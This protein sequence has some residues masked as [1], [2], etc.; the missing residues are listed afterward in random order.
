MRL[1][2]FDLNL[3]VAFKAL[4][5]ER[6]VTR[7]AER[8]NIT[9]PAMSAALRRLRTAFNDELLVASGKRML[10][11]PHAQTLAP[12][13]DDIIAASRGLIASASLFDPATSQRQFRI[14][15]SDYVCAILIRPLLAR[16]HDV[17][18][19][20]AIQ[21]VPVGADSID[22]LEQGAIDCLIAPEPFVSRAHPSELLFEEGHVVVGWDRNPLFEVPMTLRDFE[23]ASHVVVEFSD[24]PSFAEDQVRSLGH[25]RRS[26]VSVPSFTMVPW[27]LPETQ[28][29]ALMHD[30]LA[31]L[32][33]QFFPLAIA[34]P[35][36]A[37]EPMRE[38]LQYNSLRETDAG[39][40]WLR[41]QLRHEVE[42]SA[43]G[44]D[45]P[46]RNARKAAS[47]R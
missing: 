16:I 5:D 10:P 31:R 26:E 9:Q 40:Q 15:T 8:L 18:P 42:L 12:L 11:T 32:F 27:M 2:R 13:V 24:S 30:R 14:A 6:S 23:N 45:Q 41:D 34:R 20:V 28:R 1:E 7:A 36:F 46:L 25:R 3:L 22:D 47:D 4:L 33:V 37:L 39:L 44:N 17:A 19:E 21:V 38:M 29:I 35:P 43:D